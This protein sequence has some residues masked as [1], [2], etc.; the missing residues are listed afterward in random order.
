MR[1]PRSKLSYANVMATLAV[2]IALGGT[3]YAVTSLP[4][5]SVGTRQLRRHAVTNSKIAPGAVSGS[6]VKPNALTGAEINENAL[7]PVPSARFADHA[8]GADT[9]ATAGDAATVNGV[10]ASQLRLSCPSGTVRYIGECFQTAEHAATDWGTAS[11]ACVVAGGRLPAPAELAQIAQ[12]LGLQF[13][14]SEWTGDL[15][16]L[17]HA[18]TANGANGLNVVATDG[19]QGGHP[20]R[21]VLL[22]SN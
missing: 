5:N 18:I 3:S 11:M 20:Y 7:G 2:F 9:A 1:R 22:A 16:D 21:C 19:S 13:S 14:T 17:D 15:T 8:A 12:D 10:T 6:R 4:R